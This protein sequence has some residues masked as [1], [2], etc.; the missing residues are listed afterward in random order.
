MAEVHACDADT[1]IRP[2][3]TF[4]ETAYGAN[5]EDGANDG[6]DEGTGQQTIFPDLILSSNGSSSQVH[7]SLLAVI[8]GFTLEFERDCWS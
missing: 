5:E 4:E 3:F 6:K 1:L 2:F 7:K 8:A